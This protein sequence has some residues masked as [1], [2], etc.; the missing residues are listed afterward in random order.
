MD[1]WQ[2]HKQGD[3][4][5]EVSGLLGILFAGLLL[6]STPD[7]WTSQLLCRGLG[8]NMVKVAADPEGG[9]FLGTGTGL[10]DR[11]SGVR[12]PTSMPCDPPYKAGCWKVCTHLLSL[13]DIK[14]LGEAQAGRREGAT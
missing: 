13:L 8:S 5:G 10:L 1:F 6:A 14:S 11:P 7:F 9:P 4:E 3:E 2:T 12:S